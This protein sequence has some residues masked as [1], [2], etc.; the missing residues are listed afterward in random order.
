MISSAAR[1]GFATQPTLL[2][3]CTGPRDPTKHHEV[4]CDWPGVASLPFFRHRF[5]RLDL[6]WSVFGTARDM[7]APMRRIE[8]AHLCL[9]CATHGRADSNLVGRKAWAMPLK[10]EV[11]SPECDGA[12][13]KTVES[14]KNGAGAVAGR[15]CTPSA[16]QSTVEVC[17]TEPRRRYEIHHIC[18]TD[19]TSELN[20]T[21]TG[22]HLKT[23]GE[24]AE[25]ATNPDT[26]PLRIGPSFAA[27]R[28]VG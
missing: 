21:A 7:L 27:P 15:S 19:K 23:R 22:L 5:E 1:H 18:L 14:L 16:E 25:W 28:R 8:G 2:G 6:A 26:S 4:A 9:H 10:T 20:L 24:P 17:P 13:G 11:G 12:R 3:T